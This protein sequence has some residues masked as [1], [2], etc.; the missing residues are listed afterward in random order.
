MKVA[1][2]NH[3]FRNATLGL[4]H[5]G[6]TRR[7]PARYRTRP[8]PG[9]PLTAVWRGA[10]HASRP[11][12]DHPLRRPGVADD[13]PPRLFSF[14]VRAHRAGL[15][16]G[17]AGQQVLARQRLYL[18]QA[19][20]GVLAGA[21]HPPVARR[22]HGLRHAVVLALAGHP[23]K[24]GSGVHHRPGLHRAA[25]GRC[26]LRNHQRA[27]QQGY[28]ATD[29]GPGIQRSLPGFRPGRTHGGRA[30]F[31]GCTRPPRYRCQPGTC[32][33]DS[34]Q[35]PGLAG[36]GQDP[37]GRLLRRHQQCVRPASARNAAFAA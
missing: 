6:R 30:A 3:L 35:Q 11:G 12:R 32:R 10:G 31:P 27:D 1:S 16:A 28:A 20:P 4:H 5:P 13:L 8:H 18:A 7:G 14:P 24:L 22:L 2:G 23:A 15:A 25:A 26:D 9:P 29:L 19:V 33:A 36:A 34:L 37:G 21:G 17:L